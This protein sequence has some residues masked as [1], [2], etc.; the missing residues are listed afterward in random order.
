MTATS[1]NDVQ[2]NFRKATTWAGQWP[3]SA[4]FSLL[5]RWDVWCWLLPVPTGW[6][7]SENSLGTS[8][9]KLDCGSS[10]S[11]TTHSIKITMASDTLAASTFS[12]TLSDH[13]GNGSLHVSLAIWSS[14]LVWAGVFYGRDGCSPGCVG[15]RCDNAEMVPKWR[16]E[17]PWSFQFSVRACVCVCVCVIPRQFL[18]RMCVCVCVCA[19]V[20]VCENILTHG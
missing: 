4:V 17:L 16:S 7:R 20:C 14:D 1:W 19:C 5:L 12:P 15:K 3:L 11:T 6:N 18:F 2:V 9:W 10:V 13:C 8:S